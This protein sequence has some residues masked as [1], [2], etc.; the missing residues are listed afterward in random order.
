MKQITISAIIACLDEGMSREEIAEHFGVPLSEIKEHFKHPQLK[1]KKRR[2]KK[3]YQSVLV[4]DVSEDSDDY[5]TVADSNGLDE[6]SQPVDD[7]EYST[8][9]DSS[10][11]EEN[12]HLNEEQQVEEAP[13]ASEW[14]N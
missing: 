7:I 4:D 6:L 14:D 13:V 8:D 12:N 9:S 3:E 1:G 2:T 5:N 11:E 10:V